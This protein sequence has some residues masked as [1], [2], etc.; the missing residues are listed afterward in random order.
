[1]VFFAAMRGAVSFALANIYPNST[2]KRLGFCQVLINL[3]IITSFHNVFREL[4]L[5]TTI[6]VIMLTVFVIGSLTEVL[7]Y[8]FKVKVDIDAVEYIKKVCRCFN[9]LII[10]I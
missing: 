9:A 10:Q 8:T 7:L 4:V 6:V 2:G 1:M 5:H 3:I